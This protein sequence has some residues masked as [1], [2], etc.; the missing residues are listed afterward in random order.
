[1]DFFERQDKARKNTTLLVFYFGLAIVAIASIVYFVC[2]FFLGRMSH[3]GSLWNPALFGWAFCGTLTVIICGSL[4][5]M[6]ELSGGGSAVAESLGG[7]LVPPNTI[8]PH[9]RKL[10]NIVEEMA[11]AS[12]VPVPPVYVMDHEQ[13]INAF[14][15]GHTPNDAVVGVTR[16]CIATLNRDELQGVIGH[17]FS[18]ILNGDMRL[19]LRLMGFIFGIMCLAIVGRTLLR[20]RGGNSRDRNPLPLVGLVL[21]ILGWVGVFFG[22]LIQAAV[23]RQREFLADASAVQFTR[24]PDGLA[25]ALKKIAA[26]AQ[27]SVIE[28]P[29]AEG[30]SHM[31]FENAMSS[32][33]FSAFATHPPIEE[34]IRA[35]EPNWDGELPRVEVVTDAGEDV[36]AQLLNRQHTSGSRVPIPGMSAAAGLAGFAPQTTVR[37]QS[38]L[39]NMGRP[40]PLHLRYAEELRDS[41]PDGITEATR[42]SRGAMALMYALLLGRDETRRATQINELAKKIPPSVHNQL[43]ALAPEV[44][45]VAERTRLPLVNLALP[46]LRQ[47][48]S[49]EF[50]HFNTTLRWLIESDDQVDLFEFVLQKIVHRQIGRQFDPGRRDV[51]QF[52]TIK[53]LLPDCSVLLSALAQIGSAE[54]AQVAKAFR[55]GAPHLRAV[56]QEL[57]L[58]PRDECGLAEIDTAL[59][60]LAGAVPQIKKNLLEA[61]VQ[62]IGAD[63]VIQEGEAELLRGIAET[64]DC[65]MPPF[66]TSE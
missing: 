18:H 33:M 62:T 50:Q 57:R 52:Y 38:V 24:N 20:V 8:D 56:D 15:A 65:P 61:A 41:F 27:G 23:S 9:E 54:D 6:A 14:A 12:G 55:Q 10:L 19:N 63:G 60:R 43:L 39:P 34:R 49:G 21:L 11:I 26:C 3:G 17:E 44:A 5:K 45:V 2:I 22:H 37:I 13:G 64:L 36:V 59:N 16:G 30:A 53:P 7:R 51:I 29:Q 40:T 47:L 66:V 46:A 42:D 58:L 4:I 1:M 48:G 35:L 25:G 32:S 31:F 28:S